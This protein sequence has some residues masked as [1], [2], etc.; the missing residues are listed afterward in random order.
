MAM[1]TFE[2]VMKDCNNQENFALSPGCKTE[3][4]GFFTIL[5]V[6][7]NTLPE[8]YYAYD[9]RHGSDGGFC[10]LEDLVFVDYAGTFITKTPINIP[11]GGCRNLNGRG[12]WSFIN[13]ED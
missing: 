9:I 11:K 8:G 2:E 13:K 7:R 6:D 12:G 1:I 3:I 5:R 10:T 4:K